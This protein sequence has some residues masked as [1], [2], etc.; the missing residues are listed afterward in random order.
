[1][2]VEGGIDMFRRTGQR[3]FVVGD[4]VFD[5]GVKDTL[6]LL[7]VSATIGYRF[8]G[9]TAAPFVGGGIGQ[10][11]SQEKAPFDEAVS[12]RGSGP[13][14]ITFWAAWNSVLGELPV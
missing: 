3:V 2:F 1:M 10:Y 12:T 8:K 13:T 5:L 14:V 9:R 6:T 11:L 4:T 7:P